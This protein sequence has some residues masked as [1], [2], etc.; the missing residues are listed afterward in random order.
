MLPSFLQH[1]S[2][3]RLSW[4]G[5]GLSAAALGV[6]GYQFFVASFLLGQLPGPQPTQTPT[7]SPSPT[8]SR[9]PRPTTTPRPT[10]TPRPPPT[11][12]PTP[13][14]THTPTRRPTRTPTETPTRAPTRT[15]R[16]TATP[17]P[18]L[19]AAAVP[20]VLATLMTSQD[21]GGLVSAVA[22]FA[23]GTSDVL[24]TLPVTPAPR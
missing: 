6:V 12:T 23:A 17:T 4:F 14:P 15:P 18:T 5:A 3:E 9:T 20:D 10:A 2:L 7:E 11:A 13:R 22:T 16:P 21:P 8:P 1:L 24:R 19:D